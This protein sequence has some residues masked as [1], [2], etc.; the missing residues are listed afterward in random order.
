MASKPS[1]TGMRR[2]MRMSEYGWS[3]IWEC[4][5]AATACAPSSAMSTVQFILLSVSRSTCKEGV[6]RGCQCVASWYK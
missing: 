1:I 3:V 6:F 2:S 4:L 5:T